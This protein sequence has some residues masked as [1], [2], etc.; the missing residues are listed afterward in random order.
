[1]LNSKRW[2]LAEPPHLSVR[3]MLLSA[4]RRFC[5][6]QVLETHTGDQQ[7]R[8]NGRKLGITKK[9]PRLV[10]FVLGAVMVTATSVFVT[11]AETSSS[12][13]VSRR[14]VC[15]YVF[16]PVPK[17][18]LVVGRIGFK[19][20]T[21]SNLSLVR[22][23]P[24]DARRIADSQYGH[25]KGSRIVFES[26]GGYIDDS[27]IVPDWVGKKSWIP[28]PIPSYDVRIYGARLATVDPSHNHYWNVIVSA[29]SGK[30]MTVITYD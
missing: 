1:M 2:H 4:M 23:T 24:A 11:I 7:T 5:C 18:L 21:A 12:C 14:Y 28:K 8:Y 15:A 20:L 22:I 3:L 10:V 9:P 25:D 16:K 30:I 26:L 29:V 19:C 13:P 17:R 27:Q 6:R